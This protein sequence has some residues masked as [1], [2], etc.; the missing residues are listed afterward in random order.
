MIKSTNG[1]ILCKPMKNAAQLSTEIRGGIATVKQKKD[2]VAVDVVFPAEHMD[3]S[4][5]DVLF[6]KEE[7]LAT[8]PWAKRTFE[9][10]GVEVILV[11]KEYIVGVKHG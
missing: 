4:P 6:M 11:P 2:I 1:L 10:N 5:G 9:I 3:L 8:Q 7:D